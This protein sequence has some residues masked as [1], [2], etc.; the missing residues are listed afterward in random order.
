MPLSEYGVAIGNFISFFRDNPDNYGRYFHGHIS[1]T[2]PSG[3]GP[4]IIQSAIDVN[5]PDGG[6]QYFHPTQLDSAKFTTISG[7][8]DGYH[9]VTQSATSGALD[10]RR[11]PLIYM[12]LGCLS[13]LVYVLSRL[14]STDLIKWPYDPTFP[15]TRWQIDIMALIEWLTKN[16]QL[17]FTNNVGTAA[18]DQL[19]S[20]FSDPS[21]ISKVYLFGA[22]YPYPYQNNPVGLHDVHCNQGDPPGQFQVLDGIWQ[23]GGVIVKYNDYHLE[24]FFVKFET[25]TLNT[26]NQGLPS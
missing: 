7:M 23:D 19:E 21:V 8:A 1:I 6:V 11:N 10:Y 20:M 22:P 12:P 4:L 13:A 26:N 24:G 2:V 3:T 17:A 15:K 25:Q 16:N 5:K 9:I 14:T 18:L